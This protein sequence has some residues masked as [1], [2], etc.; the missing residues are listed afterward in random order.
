MVAPADGVGTKCQRANKKP[1]TGCMFRM[2]VT[3]FLLVF[4][5]PTCTAGHQASALNGDLVLALD[6]RL[7]LDLRNLNA[8]RAVLVVGMDVVLLHLIAD[9]EAA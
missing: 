1:V 5:P 6:L 9:V 2:P 3:G 8:Q 4:P 7:R